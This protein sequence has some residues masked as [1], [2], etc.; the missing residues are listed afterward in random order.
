MKVVIDIP[1]KVYGTLK[2]FES[3]FNGF[4]PS[5]IKGVLIMSVLH[6]EV[7]PKNH[8]RL[9]DADEALKAMST[10]DKFGYLPHDLIPLRSENGLNLVPYVHYDDMVA[11]I[12]NM[13]TIIEADTESEEENV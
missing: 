6:G 7:L 5:D 11:C 10:Y 12:T 3:S 2:Y 1:T 4:E 13:P 8:G 9:I